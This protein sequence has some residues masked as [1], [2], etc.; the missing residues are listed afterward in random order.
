MKQI[1]ISTIDDL[2][3]SRGPDKQKRKRRDSRFESRV[4]GGTSQDKQPIKTDWKSWTPGTK[5][6][7]E[8][9]KVEKSQVQAYTRTRKGKM[10]RVKSYQ[11]ARAKKMAHLL[12]GKPEEKIKTI[13]SQKRES[14]AT[15]D[16]ELVGKKGRE[17]ILRDKE[18]GIHELWVRNDSHAGYTIDIGGKGY[19]FAREVK[20]VSKLESMGVKEKLG[21]PFSATTKQMEHEVHRMSTMSDKALMTR[22]NKITDT[23]KLV[24]FYAVAE[25]LNRPEL[26]SHIKDV[27]MSKLGLSAKDFEPLSNWEKK[28]GKEESKI[29][30][31]KEAQPKVSEIMKKYEE[32]LSPIKRNYMNPKRAHSGDIAEAIMDVTG[33]SNET[34][35]KIISIWDKPKKEEKVTL[36]VGHQVVGHVSSGKVMSLIS[37]NIEKIGYDKWNDKP[38]EERHQQQIDWIKDKFQLNL[39]TPKQLDKIALKLENENYHGPA[40]YL[41]RIAGMPYYDYDSKGMMQNEKPLQK[42]EVKPFS[43][44]RRGRFERVKGHH[45][46]QPFGNKDIVGV[47]KEGRIADVAFKPS[48]LPKRGEVVP[49]RG[50]KLIDDIKAGTSPYQKMSMEENYLIDLG[51]YGP[52][53]EPYSTKGVQIQKIGGVDIKKIIQS[54]YPTYKGRKVSIGTNIPSELHSWWD[55]GNRSYYTFYELATGRMQGTGSNH[56]MFEAKQPR[57]LSSLPSGVVIVVRNYFG[58][59]QSIT[60]YANEGDLTSTSHPTGAL[61]QAFKN[62]S[63]SPQPKSEP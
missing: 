28:G 39:L 18:S 6:Y 14:L 26:M 44:T 10:E 40:N 32:S 63:S 20:D 41:W 48:E 23:D 51:G 17:V 8:S 57:Y 45:R 22:A 50:S 15:T 3:K 53:G 2:Y 60:I 27:G 38:L 61:D 62:F 42:G 52:R 33:V 34:A 19:E 1:A 29:K 59:K 9:R 46:D 30:H 58:S 35:D 47:I 24:R 4:W 12:S 21:E 43:R 7:E 37:K 13:G 56:P 49:I 25:K 5:E 16:F 11:S 54:A 36:E 55:E 31:T